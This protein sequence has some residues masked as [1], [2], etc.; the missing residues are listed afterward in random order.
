MDF[1]VSKQFNLSQCECISHASQ[2]TGQH[3]SF[4]C[5]FK[6]VVVKNVNVIDE[7]LMLQIA[8]IVQ[9][10]SG[11]WARYLKV[12]ICHFPIRNARSISIQVFSTRVQPNILSNCQTTDTLALLWKG[13]PLGINTIEK[14]NPLKTKVVYWNVSNSVVHV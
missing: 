10:S 8:R 5:A 6:V 4:R 14:D 12:M 11:F 9:G 2:T 7:T 1:V 13:R 3:L